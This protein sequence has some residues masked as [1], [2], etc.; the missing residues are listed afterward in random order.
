MLQQA[1][2]WRQL[3]IL[4]S[5]LM[6]KDQ[7]LER[8]F[9]YRDVVGCTTP[10]QAALMAYFLR[11]LHLRGYVG[12]FL[13]IGV[14]RGR[15]SM[16]FGMFLAGHRK[17]HM[18]DPG[19]EGAVLQEL[20]ENLV[21]LNPKLDLERDIIVDKRFSH[22]LQRD[23]AVHNRGEYAFIH[24]DGGHAIFDVYR[25][26]ELAEVLLNERGVVICDD[27]FAAGRPGVTEGVYKFLH[28]RPGV[29]RMLMTGYN[30][31]VLVRV[32]YY[33]TWWRHLVDT[34]GDYME[35]NWR[36]VQIHLY[37][38]PIEF[39]TL[40]LVE[41]TPDQPMYG[42]YFERK[43]AQDMLRVLQKAVASKDA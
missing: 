34:I 4:E 8:Y 3:L 25:D 29:F 37:A 14:Y 12:N 21:A 17:L 2:D 16:L 5:L 32:D 43:E 39:P 27:F 28:D 1:R 42:G 23:Y 20:Q 30:K 24:I 15:S 31:A 19:V 26:L 35:V 9:S 33:E 36:L 11:S 18:V 40:G 22:E 7:A 41:R 6:E 10:P 38:S 13:E